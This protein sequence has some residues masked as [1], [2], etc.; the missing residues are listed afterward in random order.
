MS[1]RRHPSSSSFFDSLPWAKRKRM[2]VLKSL[3]L[4]ACVIGANADAQPSRITSAIDNRQRLTLRGHVNPKARQENERGR[5]APSLKLTYVTLV[6]AQS[7]SQQADLDQ[8]LIEQQTSGSPNYRRWL[9]PD[10]YAVRFG[11]SDDDLG[12][13][14]TWLEGQGLTIAAVA[15]G[16]NWI[17]VNGDAAQIEAAFQTE[18]HQYVVNG[19]N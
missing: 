12:K 14:K 13:I 5:V 8:L 17:A 11:V 15:R 9:T 19:E 1:N 4:M 10:E 2:K 18:L 16:R 6:L 7:E 3:I